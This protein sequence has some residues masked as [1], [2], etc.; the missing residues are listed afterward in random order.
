MEVCEPGSTT[1]CTTVPNV[2]V[3]TGST[4]LRLLSGAVSGLSLP[5]ITDRAAMTF[6]SASSLSAWHTSGGR[7]RRRTFIWPGKPLPR[8]RFTLSAISAVCRAYELPQ[9][10]TSGAVDLNTVQALG[11]NGILGVGNLLRIAARLAPPLLTVPA[12][13]FSCPSGAC[14][15][16]AVPTATTKGQFRNP[17]ALFAK[18]ITAC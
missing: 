11:A 10:G 17:V 16:T 2:L 7:L 13:Y 6:R 5:S 14:Q 12:V 8:S 18:T 15:I 3:D 9:P 1:N 4:G